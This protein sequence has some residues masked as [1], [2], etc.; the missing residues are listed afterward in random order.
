MTSDGCGASAALRADQA[1][2]LAANARDVAAG[3]G[4]GLTGAMLDRL[5]LDPGRLGIADAV[6]SVADLPDPVGRGD[7]AAP[8]GPT[9]LCWRGCGCRSA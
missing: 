9:G 5:R 6:D 7:R 8:N 2:I 4:G 1:A 3:R